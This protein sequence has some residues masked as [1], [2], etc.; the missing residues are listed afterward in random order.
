M[1]L[2]T[3]FFPKALDQFRE[4]STIVMIYCIPLFNWLRGLHLGPSI[5][6]ALPWGRSLEGRA[7]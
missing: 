7:P 6:T 1:V 2:V 4:L 3:G 5:G